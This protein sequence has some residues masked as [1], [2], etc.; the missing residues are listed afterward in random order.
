MGNRH[1]NPHSDDKGPHAPLMNEHLTLIKNISIFNGRSEDLIKGK[2]VVLLDNKIEKIIPAG[3]SKEGEYGKVIDGK[4]G[5][6]SPGIIDNHSHLMMGVSQAEFF[7]GPFQYVTCMAVRE[8][9]D[10]LMRGVTT[11]RDVGGNIFG[12][13]KAV[14][15]GLLPGPRIYGSGSLISQYSGHVDFRNPNEM[16]KE[17]GGP[18]ST[19]ERSEMNCGILATGVDQVTAAARHNL[20]LGADFIKIAN[21]GGVSS[22]TD[23][24]YVNE[25]FEEETRAAVRV[26]EDYGTYVATHVFNPVGIKRAL[27]AG[28]KTIEHGHLIDEEAMELLVGKEAILSTQVYVM[29]MLKPI[30]TDA[31][32][33][34]KLQQAL[35][36]MDNM[37]KLAKK[38]KAKIVYGTD[39]LFDYEGRKDQLKDLPLRK[40][41]FT[42]AEIMIQA[43][44]NAGDCVALCGKRNIYGKLGVIEEGAMA[45]VLIY[46]KNPIED[47]AVVEDHK[48]TLKLIIKDGKVYKNT[49]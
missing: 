29:A 12:L 17:W 8:A 23:P 26:A 42:S 31:V 19:V 34:G 48:N 3:S 28:V 9:E 46:D 45:D 25:F 22:F 1:P 37:F 49:L 41:W 20:Y 33:A 14:N 7:N 44:G 6:L 39:L 24:L 15:S 4:G 18:I 36:G 47:V 13:R 35:D 21:G 16:P 5:Y 40:P 11:C 38:Y 27:N 10:M 32:R 30:Y 43:T 2:D